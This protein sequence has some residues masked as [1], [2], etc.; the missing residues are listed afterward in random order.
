MPP[1]RYKQVRLSDALNL[2]KENLEI[3]DQSI[4]MENKVETRT[5]LAIIWKTETLARMPL[6]V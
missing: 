2:P 3:I 6:G 5:V 1:C 4:L